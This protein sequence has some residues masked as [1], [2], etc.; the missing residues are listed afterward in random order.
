[1]P[2][3]RSVLGSRAFNHQSSRY[4]RGNIIRLTAGRTKSRSIKTLLNVSRG[5]VRLALDFD[6]IRNEGN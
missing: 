1:M 2:P 4:S 5:A 6:Y 3:H